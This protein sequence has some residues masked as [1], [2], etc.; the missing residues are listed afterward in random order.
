MLYLLTGE[1]ITRSRKICQEEN[2]TIFEEI[3]GRLSSRNP[4]PK[5]QSAFETV[6]APRLVNLPKL[7][8]NTGVEPVQVLPCLCFPSRPVT[9]LAIRQSITKVRAYP[10]FV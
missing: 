3:G 1:E 9:V 7:A 10:D 5:G 4:S 8:A 6:P 2:E